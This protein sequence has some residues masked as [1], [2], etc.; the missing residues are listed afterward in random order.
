MVNQTNDSISKTN[1]SHDQNRKIFLGGLS[2]YT[3]DDTLRDYCG[4]FGRFTDCLV[5]RNPEGKSRGFGFVTY[6]DEQSVEQFMQARPHTIDN[7]QIDPKR[8]MPREDQNSTEAH[9]SVKKLFVAG[10][11]DGI[12]ETALREYFTRF[13]NVTE[14]SIMKD[15]DGKHRGFAFVQFDDYD[16]V[17]KAILAKPHLI[18][19]RQVDIKKAIPKEKMQEMAY[20]SPASNRRPM[21]PPSHRP[22][23]DQGSYP[24]PWANPNGS[25]HG[26]PSG[27]AP[28]YSSQGYNSSMNSNPYPPSYSTNMNQNPPQSMM[29]Y[30]NNNNNN[31]PNS[32]M[33][34][35]SNPT[36][37][38][39]Q[40][41]PSSSY[42]ANQSSS[43]G[44]MNMPFPTSTSTGSV[45]PPPPPPPSGYNDGTTSAG[46]PNP[47]GNNND[48]GMMSHDYSGNYNQMSS[49]PSRGGGGP[50]RGGRGGYAGNNYNTRPGPYPNRGGGRGGGRGRG[51]GQ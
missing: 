9:L 45:P 48:Y 25:R 24:S 50:M 41:M 32:T 36:N 11:K 20:P 39:M 33:P 18:N 8:A 27:M 31:N 46:A 2:Y 30:N 17:D 5:M 23:Y 26:G 38:Y 42:G 12:D 21:G 15:R 35:N 28:P 1:N 51:R 49:G 44:Q 13:G 40:P 37:S 14:V 29:N 10:L 4:R 7:R 34:Y 6:E 22:N 19:G 3:L 47:Y 43:Y 16:A